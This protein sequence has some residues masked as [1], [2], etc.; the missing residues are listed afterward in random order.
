MSITP[1][2]HLCSHIRVAVQPWTCHLY[3]LLI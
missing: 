1:T 2:Q 3:R